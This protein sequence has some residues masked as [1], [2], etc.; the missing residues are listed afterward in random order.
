MSRD[1]PPSNAPG[2]GGGG[3]LGIPDLHIMRTQV[4]IKRISQLTNR[5]QSSISLSYGR[6]WTG[7]VLGNIKDEWKWL[8]ANNKPH[9][10]PDKIPKWYKVLVSFGQQHRDWL[11]SIPTTQ[12]TSQPQAE[13]AWKR[14]IQQPPNIDDTWKGLWSSR[15]DN[16]TKEFLWKL[17]HRM[18][19]TKKYLQR[20]GMQVNVQCPFCQSPEDMHHAILSCH[21]AL[22]FWKD[23]EPLL[24]HTAGRTLP[25]TFDTLVFRRNLPRDEQANVICYHILAAGAE[26]LWRTQNKKVYDANAKMP[27]L[28]PKVIA[29]L[30]GKI[31][32]DF[33]TNPARVGQL[34][35]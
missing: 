14:Y 28:K 22:T 7:Q 10:D 2:G 26:L 20:W 33:L 8:R 9:G 27:D 17:T 4:H 25:L 1:V 3:V 30:K 18:L 31:R 23:L 15:S 19:T 29:E 21:W 11:N 16:W 24:T 35:N 13:H 34:L 5:E 6:Y 12:I 32:T